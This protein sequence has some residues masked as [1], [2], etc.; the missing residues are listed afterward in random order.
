MFNTVI[1]T[2]IHCELNAE[3]ININPAST[4]FFKAV[5]SVCH[6]G[7]FQYVDK[8]ILSS[9]I[10]HSIKY[11][12]SYFYYF[13]N[14]FIW[15]IGVTKFTLWSVERSSFPPFY[16][17]IYCQ[18]SLGNHDCEINFYSALTIFYSL[19]MYFCNYSK[20]N[21]YRQLWHRGRQVEIIWGKGSVVLYTLVY[22]LKNSCSVQ[23]PVI[24]KY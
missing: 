19:S 15:N 23:L 17:Y 16:P 22:Q 18:H 1:N 14:R 8:I 13:T 7:L 12:T 5:K 6:R 21:Y 20:F 2:Q 4:Q 11:F 9:Y 3:I 24:A 10:N